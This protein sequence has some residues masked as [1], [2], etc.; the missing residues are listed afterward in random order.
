MANPGEIL[1]LWSVIAT[2]KQDSMINR[3]EHKQRCTRI[4]DDEQRRPADEQRARRRTMAAFNRNLSWGIAPV[5]MIGTPAYYG[6]DRGLIFL[7]AWIDPLF[8][9]L[10]LI[11]FFMHTAAG[12]CCCGVFSFTMLSRSVIGG[13]ALHLITYAL[14]QAFIAAHAALG[15]RFVVRRAAHKPVDPQLQGTVSPRWTAANG[16]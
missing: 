16:D 11:L 14:N 1:M 12:F 6:P 7:P 8:T 13:G 3:T 9:N 15:L 10:F 4:S 2:L 5:P